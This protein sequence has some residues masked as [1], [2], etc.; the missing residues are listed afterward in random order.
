MPHEVI[1]VNFEFNSRPFYIANIPCLGGV[2]WSILNTDLSLLE[3]WLTIAIDNLHMQYNV[4]G[5][6][7]LT[8]RF[9][10]HEFRCGTYSFNQF[11]TDLKIRDSIVIS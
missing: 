4:P 2:C 5:V 7:H 9:L 11:I 8:I 3:S 1:Y 10:F 6:A